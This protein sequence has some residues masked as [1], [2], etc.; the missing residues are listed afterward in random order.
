MHSEFKDIIH[1]KG[2][3]LLLKKLAD[4]SRVYYTS[5]TKLFCLMKTSTKEGVG[6]C[7]CT[8]QGEPIA[9]RDIPNA[10]E[11]DKMISP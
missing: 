5:G 6:F 11:F 9:Q 2:K 1:E 7:V 3:F 8:D 10:D 4:S